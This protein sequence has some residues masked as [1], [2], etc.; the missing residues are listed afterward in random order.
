MQSESPYIKRSRPESET[1]ANCECRNRQSGHREGPGSESRTEWRWGSR[2]RD[3]VTYKMQ[4]INLCLRGRSR[5]RKLAEL[6][7]HRPSELVAVHYTILTVCGCACCEE[8]RSESGESRR[9]ARGVPART[10][11]VICFVSWVQAVQS[12]LP[13]GNVMA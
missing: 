2:F 5:K 4:E 11:P 12:R 7:A 1:K 8:T 9:P 6:Q 3:G 10:A 13:L